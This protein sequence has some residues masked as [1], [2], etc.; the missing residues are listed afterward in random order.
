MPCSEKDNRQVDI[1]IR[2]RDKEGMKKRKKGHFMKINED[3]TRKKC[4]K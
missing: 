4:Q 1:W 2:E 3:M